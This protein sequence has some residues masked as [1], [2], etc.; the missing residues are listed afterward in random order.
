MIFENRQDAGKKMSLFL[1]EYKNQNV[2]VFALP[3]GGVVVAAEI[4]KFLQAPLDVLLAHKIGHPY[5]PEYAVAAVSE[6]GYLIVSS[7]ERQSLNESWLENQKA[8]QLS[9]MKKKRERYLEGRKEI[10]AEG[11]IAILVD[12][13]I[14]TGLTMRAG[15]EELKA[16][17]PKKIVVV[18]PVV[19]KSTADLIKQRVDDL[20]GYEIDDID[21]L[22]S[23]GAY[24]G[25]FSQVE[26]YEVIKILKT[27]AQ[28]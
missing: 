15:I 2:V 7:R 1:E 18:T 5:Q 4:A 22:G 26:D 14:A 3:R 27:L 13:G 25:E 19:P 21:F 12:D 9:E 24:Y 11:K 16:R 17:H 8:I 28:A 10:S 6:K 20:V 23:I